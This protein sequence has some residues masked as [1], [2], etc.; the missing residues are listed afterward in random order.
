[1]W[2]RREP[3]RRNPQRELYTYIALRKK[4]TPISPQAAPSPSP[5]PP[6][7]TSS[8]FCRLY[9]I[10]TSGACLLAQAPLFFSFQKDTKRQRAAL[11]RNDERT[12]VPTFS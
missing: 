7:P 10:D 8:G 4:P 9:F 6:H 1:V 3:L 12:P 11:A 5:P 2:H